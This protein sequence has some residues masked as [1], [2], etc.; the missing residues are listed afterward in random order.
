[1]AKLSALFS[2][3]KVGNCEIKNRIL[4]SG[5]V[6]AQAVGGLFTDGHLRYYEARAKGGIGLIVMEAV[7]VSPHSLLMGDA[8]FVQG[9]RK[10]NIPQL[11]KISDAV[12]AHG[13]KL[14]CQA[15]HGG[16][17]ITTVVSKVHA[18]SVSGIP[19]SGVG[20]APA[21]MTEEDIKEAI[22]RYVDFALLLKE[23]GCDGVELH[24]AH[25]Y[26]PQQFL[27][28]LYNIRKDKY[29]GSIE[30]RMRFSLELIDAVRTAVGKDFVVGLRTT[31]DELVT[32]GITLEF[33][34]EVFPVWDQ[35]GQ[36][37]YLNVSVGNYRTVPPMIAP[38]M[39]PPRPFVYLAA[40]LKQTVDI[41]VFTA[42]RINDPV[43]ANDIIENNEADMV[44]MTRATLCDPEMPNKAKEGRLDDIRQCVGCNEGCWERVLMALPITCAQNPESGNEGLLEIGTAPSKKK[45]IVVGGGVAGMEAAIVAKQ[46]GHDVTLYE[47]SSEFGGAL[48]IAAKSPAREELGQVPRFMIHEMGRLGIKSH[49][50]TEVKLSTIESENPDVVVIATGATTIE[51]PSP[52]IVG[53][54]A[55]IEIEDG[56]HVVT[57]EDVLE[58]KVETGHRVVVADLQT[59]MKG[60]ITAEVLADQGKDV[61]I[62]PPLPVRMLA[63]SPY[64]M[65]GATYGIQV[66]NINMKK[67]KRIADCA[68]KKA[69]P[70]KVIIRNFYTEEDEE[71][72]AD[73]LV[74]SYWRSS[75]ISLYYELEGKVKELYRIGDCVAPRRYMDA[76]YEGY[77]TAR[78]I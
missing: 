33:M 11:K 43:M 15:W 3:I 72:E 60:L 47:K 17:Q 14:F 73:T 21:V 28:P 29:G 41:P 39:V 52:D 68:V 24:V 45:V 63:N 78:K 69:M 64:D 61:T 31:G 67:V 55:S 53:P 7:S 19:S 62:T 46:R 51:D 58:K 38:M 1:M 65:D 50:N 75:N 30:N 77:H 71:L 37:D 2:P 34:K 10:E 16:N 20:E 57:A 12:H 22:Q 48:L 35:T 6:T 59:Y 66:A 4:Q 8:G 70:G 9:W 26:L 5:H 40:E 25:G 74:I 32:G 36:V 56:A 76:V 42:I 49:L 54:E 27:S 13:T 23:G 18:Q 44:V